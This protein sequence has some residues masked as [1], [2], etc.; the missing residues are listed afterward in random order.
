MP[1]YP[2]FDGRQPLT[3][4][5]MNALTGQAQANSRQTVAP[6]A[7]IYNLGSLGTIVAPGAASAPAPT[8]PPALTFSGAATYPF[9]VSPIP[10][11]LTVAKI[12][13]TSFFDTGGYFKSQ[14]TLIT[15]P[16]NGYYVY[17]VAANYHF[18]SGNGQIIIV[19]VA[20]V[21]TQGDILRLLLASSAPNAYAACMGVSLF[22]QDQVI[23]PVVQADSL[24]TFFSNQRQDSPTGFGFWIYLLGAI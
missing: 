4:D 13:G 9:A 21:N 16:R 14:L 20:L 8:V 24:G 1:R 3:K 19:G 18:L 22:T 11:T 5:T 10:N 12:V 17:G 23:A 6:G 15:I 7:D 2:R